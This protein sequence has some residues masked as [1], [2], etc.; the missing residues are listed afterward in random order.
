MKQ[1][2]RNLL[3]PMWDEDE[4]DSPRAEPVAIPRG[5]PTQSVCQG[6]RERPDRLCAACGA[7]ASIWTEAGDGRHA[8]A[9][10][11]TCHAVL[12]SGRPANAPPLEYLFAGE[13]AATA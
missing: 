6:C 12:V 3:E 2:G 10:C 7:P 5:E 8:V 9:W 13:P 4:R 11:A 1:L